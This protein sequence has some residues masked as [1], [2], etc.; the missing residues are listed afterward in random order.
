SEFR[1]ARIELSGEAGE[2]VE[3]A[4]N[5]DFAG[6]Q[7]NFRGVYIGLKGLPYG[8]LRAGQFKEPYGL[9]QIT[10]ANYIPVMERSLMNAFVPGYNAGLMVFDQAAGERMTWAVGVFRSGNDNGE[11][12]KGDGE[13]ALTGRVTGL[14]VV[15]HEGRDYVH[16]GLSASHR[17]P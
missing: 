3:W 16:L 6:G 17:N 9:E 10:S 1:R 11:I 13:W 8:N 7:T 12:S 14:P 5:F 4:S 2:R 15:A